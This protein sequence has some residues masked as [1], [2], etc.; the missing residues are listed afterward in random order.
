MPAQNDP[1][2]LWGKEDST[3]SRPA[4]SRKGRSEASTGQ[5]SRIQLRDRPRSP[6]PAHWAPRSPSPSGGRRRGDVGGGRLGRS[7]S[8]RKPADDCEED[9][10][11][12]QAD[13]RAKHLSLSVENIP[14]DMDWLELKNI[15]RI[16]G[17]VAHAKCVK[18]PGTHVGFLEF[19][20]PDSVEKAV[21]GL[22]GSICLGCKY[23]MRVRPGV[24]AE[25]L[26]PLP[27]EVSLRGDLRR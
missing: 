24:S 11:Y 12:K 17:F 26:A 19:S 21:A 23:P 18:Q 10:L 2:G 8:P 25:S 27:G 22:D 6:S 9:A 3:S 5:S 7:R 20:A 16:Y 15:G 4:K 13:W 1:F 14:W